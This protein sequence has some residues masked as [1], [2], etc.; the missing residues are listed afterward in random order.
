MIC[1][2]FFLDN[3]LLASFSGF[4]GFPAPLSSLS[5]YMHIK[6]SSNAQNSDEGFRA[7]ITKYQKTFGK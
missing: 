5:G 6:F 1:G 3:T 4:I 7:K 2:Y